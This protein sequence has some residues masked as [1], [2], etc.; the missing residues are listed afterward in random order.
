MKLRDVC[1]LVNGRAYNQAELLEKEVREPRVG[2]FFTN[3]HWYYSDLELEQKKYCH[4]G[5]LLYAWSVSF[6]PRIWSG[7]KVIFH[8]HIW[9]VVPDLSV[10]DQKFLYMFLL[11]DKEQIK[12]DQGTG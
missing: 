2:N 5:D 7:G 3:E 11:W 9:R 8:Y 12:Q 10:I 1:E 4:N 6:G